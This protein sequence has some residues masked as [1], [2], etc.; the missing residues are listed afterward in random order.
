MDMASANFGTGI[1][2]GLGS[3]ASGIA[4]TVLNQKNIDRNFAFQKDVF[5][6]Q[7][8]LQREIFQRE[9]NSIRR[10]ATDIAAA[11]GNP[12]MA[13]E[14]NTGAA[15]GQNIPVTA[16]QS[17]SLQIDPLVN[18]SLSQISGAMQQFQQ[19]QL[20]DAVIKNTD[21]QASK[22]KAETITESI[23]QKQMEMMTAKTEEE[24]ERIKLEIEALDYDLNYSINHDLRTHD[25]INSVYNAGKDMVNNLSSLLPENLDQLDDTS[26]LSL[27][28]DIGLTI[29]PG[30]ASLKFASL[31]GKAIKSALKYLKSRNG[32]NSTA[33]FYVTYKKLTG[34]APST[35]EVELFKEGITQKVPFSDNKYPKSYYYRKYGK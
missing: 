16:P 29:I 19:F 28:A 31:G 21:A 32:I 23:R 14:T 4:N 34:R 30:L 22:T 8:Q 17:E 1:L 7:K 15:A 13:W 25:P 10:R 27:A 33:E 11:G 3:F 26:L 6:Y 18:S 35:K 2:S 9:D 5:N 20:N 12:A 24:K